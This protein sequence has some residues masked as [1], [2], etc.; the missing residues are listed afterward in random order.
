MA[1]PGESWTE[2]LHLS[3]RTK[4]PIGSGQAKNGTQVIRFDT[5]F[6]ARYGEAETL[7]PLIRR[8][9]ANNPSPFTFMGTGTAIVGH[10]TVAI[11]DP[12]PDDENHIAALKRALG[13]ERVSHIL[14]THTHRDHSPAARAMQKWSGAPIYG[15]GRHPSRRASGAPQDDE[16]E[17]GGDDDFAP[18]IFVKDGDVISG[19][20][21]TFDAIHTPGHISN[22]LCFGLREERALFSG[23]HVMAWSTSVVA[24]PDG[25]MA[26][27][28]ASLRKLLTRDDLVYWPT[29][30]GPIKDPKRFVDS[31]V[32]HRLER[33]AQILSAV[34]NVATITQIVSGIYKGLDSR[35]IPA[36]SLNVLAHLIRLVDEGRVSCDASP[37]LN[38]RFRRIR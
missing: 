5:A 36:A 28:I 15:F 38:A 31:L 20:G 27:Y 22:H 16:I 18:D 25:S 37:G 33:E 4:L 26:D 10:G 6:A 17:E 9:L 24:P 29:H 8:V 11:I 1:N 2:P 30:G 7:S 19:D 23:D 34:E 21:F 32:A 13:A 12:G 14:I 3:Q 35:L